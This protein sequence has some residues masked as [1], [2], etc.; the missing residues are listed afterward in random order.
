MVLYYYQTVRPLSLPQEQW[1]PHSIKAKYLHK[2]SPMKKDA[3]H[4][5]FI[6]WS[7]AGLSFASS[8][9][10]ALQRLKNLINLIRKEEMD[11]CLS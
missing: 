1:I 6:K 10:V 8:W 11:S 2:L 3:T 5:Q 7:T 4:G 9:L